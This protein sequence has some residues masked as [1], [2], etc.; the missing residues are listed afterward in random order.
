MRT[1][2]FAIALV[3]LI[4]SCT[5]APACGYVTSFAFVPSVSYA[6][7][8]VQ[9]VQP[10]ITYS[11]PAYAVASAPAVQVQSVAYAAPVCPSLTSLYAAPAFLPSVSYGSIGFNSVGYG[12]GFNRFG[13][14]TGFVGGFGA[15]GVP[16]RFSVVS[17]STFIGGGV[18]SVNRFAARGVTGGFAPAQV[19]LIN[20]NGFGGLGGAFRSG[21]RR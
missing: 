14:R 11:V 7:P 3:A 12:V 1:K 2:Q 6:A 16:G 21:F 5:P 9:F 17:R 19:G 4:A 15:V 20:I 18:V 13:I 8:V 10:A